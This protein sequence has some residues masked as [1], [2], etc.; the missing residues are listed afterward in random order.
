LTTCHA[1]TLLTL[2]VWAGAEADAVGWGGVAMV[3]G[4]TGMAIS[5]VRKG[6]DEVRTGARRDDVVKVRR[7]G[8]GRRPHE[9]VFPECYG[10]ALLMG[11]AAA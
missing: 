7:A 1:A 6:P 8:G 10:A 5:T 11:N 4:A 9:V 2:T 3:A